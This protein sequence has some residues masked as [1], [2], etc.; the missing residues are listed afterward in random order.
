M[1]TSDVIEEA[2]MFAENFKQLAKTN[3]NFRKVIYTGQ[4]S[5]VVAMSLPMGTDI[6]MET[7]P[8]IDQIFFIIDGSG[9]VTIDGE[10][11]YF[12]EKELIFVPAGSEHNVINTGDED[13][14]L[15]TIYSPPAHPDGTIEA[16]KPV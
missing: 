7:H 10:K 3:T 2:S 11:R 15:I 16:T 5:Q 14:K 8:A 12:E 4:H 1:Y 6:G 9:E 13:L